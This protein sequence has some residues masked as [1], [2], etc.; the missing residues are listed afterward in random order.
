MCKN[1]DD[2]EPAQPA[3]VDCRLEMIQTPE[4]PLLEQA[5]ADRDSMHI[6]NNNRLN[7]NANSNDRNPETD[8]S[9]T[10]LDLLFILL[11]I[12]THDYDLVS[13]VCLT[14]EYFEREKTLHGYLT[15]AFI[16]L[17]AITITWMSSRM[18][19]EDSEQVSRRRSIATFRGNQVYYAK[20][21]DEVKQFKT[22]F[23]KQFRIQR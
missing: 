3:N 12:L 7:N 19:E 18:Y 4:N 22:F 23:G 8:R 15:V 14:I 16:I 21:T 17:P 9:V 6:N 10:I 20:K 13:D 1:N 5:N 11:P 2:E